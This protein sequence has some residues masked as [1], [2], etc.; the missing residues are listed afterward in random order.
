MGFKYIAFDQ[1]TKKTGW[2]IFIDGKLENYGIIDFSKEKDSEKRI[3]L[4][5]KEIL[6][7][8]SKEKPN[9]I[10]CEHPQGEG[11]NVLV[12]SKLSEI[13]GIIRAYSLSK[14]IDFIEIMPSEWRRYCEMSQGKKKR[15]ELKQMS[16][17]FVKEIFNKDVSEDTADAI[18]QGYG[19][20]KYYGG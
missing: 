5:G 14:D 8:L 6:R 2:S 15:D 19:Y 9:M 3:N 11:R 17:D 12:V 20:I 18:C 13:I 10:S 7:L 1:S 16:I 4:M